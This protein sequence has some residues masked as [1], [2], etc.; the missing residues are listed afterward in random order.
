MKKRNLVIAYVYS[1]SDD[2]FALF[3]MPDNHPSGATVNSFGGR[4]EHGE[5]SEEAI[6]R[7]TMEEVGYK[8]NSDS[9]HQ[10]ATVPISTEFFGEVHMNVYVIVTNKRKP[11]LKGGEWKK[12]PEWTS[13]K[14]FPWEDLPPNNKQWLEPVL[15][16]FIDNL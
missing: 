15:A 3:D 7:E 12:S 10:V 2:S 13:L 5:T 16:G 1:K 9:L 8:V 6:I 11:A 14:D 4:V